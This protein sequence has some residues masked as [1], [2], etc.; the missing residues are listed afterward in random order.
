MRVI[1]VDDEPMVLEEV[2]KLLNQQAD[3]EETVGFLAPDKALEWLKTN[4]PD[5]AFLD[6]NPPQWRQG[7]ADSL[8]GLHRPDDGAGS[9]VLR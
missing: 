5:A 2:K 7:F 4:Q 6:I 3:V 9:P 1:C 8:Q